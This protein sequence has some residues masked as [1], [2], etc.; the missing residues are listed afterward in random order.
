MK[1]ESEPQP[2]VNNRVKVWGC[3]MKAFPV[4]CALISAALCSAALAHSW[5]PMPCCNNYDCAPILEF[6]EKPNPSGGVP[7]TWVRT[8]HGVAFVPR[9]MPRMDSQDNQNHACMREFIPGIMTL[10]CLFVAK[11][12]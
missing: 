11:A 2:F 3:A 9:D 6:I 8:K 5:Y 10:R 12:L 4:S 7:Y 1:A